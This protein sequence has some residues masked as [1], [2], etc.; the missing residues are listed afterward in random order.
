MY[1]LFTCSI[2][3][4]SLPNS[5]IWIFLVKY[6][7]IGFFPQCF[8]FRHSFTSLLYSSYPSKLFFILYYLPYLSPSF[9]YPSFSFPMCPYPSI[10]FHTLPDLF[11]PLWSVLTFSLSSIPILPV[12]SPSQP[13]LSLP[14]IPIL[15]VR[16]TC[17]FHHT[18][19][20]SYI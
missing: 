3:Y 17:H 13:S 11:Q 8:L 14:S 9:L 6:K 10:S 12:P 2:S 5:C 16:P 19:F 15:P 7:N 18:L 20:F 4:L 1:L